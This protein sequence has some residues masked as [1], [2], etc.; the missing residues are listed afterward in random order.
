M[1]PSPFGA[2]CVSRVREPLEQLRAANPAPL[3]DVSTPD[4]WR[5]REHVRRAALEDDG[6]EDTAAGRVRSSRRA[7]RPPG[8]PAWA[9]ARRR[10]AP[11]AWERRLALAVA[12]PAVFALA[13]V[14]AFSTGSAPKH[15]DH[16]CESAH[17]CRRSAHVGARAKRGVS[18]PPATVVHEQTTVVRDCS[19]SGPRCAQGCAIPVSA[20]SGPPRATPDCARAAPRPCLEYVRTVGQAPRLARPCQPPQLTLRAPGASPPDRRSRRQKRR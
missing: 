4:W 10:H 8:W 7:G 5:I 2:L 3:P 12:V 19:V 6:A 11:R 18:T 16:A 14:L 20:R 1:R 9:L 17:G 13:S 15:V